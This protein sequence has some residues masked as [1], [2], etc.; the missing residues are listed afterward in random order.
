MWL[1]YRVVEALGPQDPVR[2]IFYARALKPHA[3]PTSGPDPAIVA[4]LQNSEI[5]KAYNAI[6]PERSVLLYD[7]CGKNAIWCGAAAFSF[8]STFTEA[9][10]IAN[11]S[12]PDP[13]ALAVSWFAAASRQDD[14]L[15][16]ASFASLKD[17]PFQ[18]LAITNR[19][20]LAHLDGNQWTGAEIHFVYGLIP[21]PG[22]GVPPS[23][24]VIL[25]FELPEFDRATFQTLAKTWI[26][27]SR[28]PDGQYAGQLL[29]ALRSSGFSP[30]QGAT[31]LIRVRSRM[32]HM[33]N[34]GEWRLSQL[35]IDPASSDAATRTHFSPAKLNDQIHLDVEQNSKL[36]L[37]LWQKVKT[38]VDSGVLEYKIP[39]ELLEESSVRYVPPT[40]GLGTPPGV[41]DASQTA[42]DVL[43]LQQCTL[44]HTTESNTCFLHIPN[45]LRT[46]A[47]VPSGFLI[48]QNPQSGMNLHPS[49]VDLY[50]GEQKVVWRVTLSYTT[51]GGRADGPCETVVSKQVSRNFHDVARRTLF[52]AAV[53]TDSILH[54]ARPL[55]NQFS[56]FFTE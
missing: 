54:N 17:A 10:K 5:G 6:R 41:C 50:Y 31:R 32:N 30:D 21:A 55:A 23:L 35:L 44:C 45:R 39:D 38:A 47:S 14:V 22:V 53:Q 9:A 33:I 40:Q 15:Q 34:G 11:P 12:K 36:Y 42:R 52:L 7:D 16:G 25:E 28:V 20:D 49:L 2:D 51:Y 26:E 19:M 43:A 37:G 3:K 46:R 56:T 29:G 13:E 18:L 4:A 8:R 27:L 24:T 1:H 48:G